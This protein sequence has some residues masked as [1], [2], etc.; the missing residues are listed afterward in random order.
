MTSLFA[1]IVKHGATPAKWLMVLGMAYTLAT[2]VLVIAAP[3]EAAPAQ[4]RGTVAHDPGGARPGADLQSIVD[5]NLFG[6][7]GAVSAATA[8][9]AAARETPVDTRL[10]LTLHGVFVADPP[11]DSTA[12]LA[13]QGRAENLYR[14]GE[15][16]PGNATLEA[17]A[18]NHVL[19]RRGRSPE[20]L[21]FPEPDQ[22][23]ATPSAQ[24][25]SAA[26]T[27]PDTQ[28]SLG[29]RAAL[30]ASRPE[31]RSAPAPHRPQAPSP[32]EMAQK[33]R[34]HLKNDPRGA[35]GELGLTP[36]SGDAAAGYRLDRLA[37]SPYLRQT[38]LK[39]GDVILSVNGQLLGDVGR[40]R[41]ELDNLLAQGSAR[42]EVQ[43]GDRRFFIT[44]SL[45]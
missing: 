34:E 39:P 14:I 32:R 1:H 4:P 43:R 28:A 33:Y 31:Q 35:L 18:I 37:E 2:V 16:V 17:V 40:D 15:A 36:V 44:A 7:P 30:N 27:A 45:R 29:A 6:S 19:L 21:A 38:G 9:A 23:L 11:Q 8:R 22:R 5:A 13:H 24:A 41:L 12:I 3:P 26:G 25:K 20:R 10:P 42:L